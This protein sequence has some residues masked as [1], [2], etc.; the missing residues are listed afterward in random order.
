VVEESFTLVPKGDTIMEEVR[1]VEV[2]VIVENI[3]T[4]EA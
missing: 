4:I 2:Q 1:I 3:I